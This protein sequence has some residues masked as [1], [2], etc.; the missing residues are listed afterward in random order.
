MEETWRHREEIRNLLLPGTIQHAI[1]NVAAYRKL[2]GSGASQLQRI[3]DLRNLPIVEKE[4]MLD[5]TESFRDPN[6]A[7]MLIQHTTGTS[8]NMLVLHR[9]AEEVEFINQFFTE[10]HSELSSD[11][12][13]CISLTANHHGNPTPIPYPG[14]V[15]PLD[16]NDAGWKRHVEQIVSRP[17]TFTG[18]KSEASILVG[19][20]SQLRI[21]TC[22]LLEAGYDFSRSSV[23]A[24]LSTGDLISERLQK[25]Y[26]STWRVPLHD[27]YSLTEIGGG[28]ANKCDNCGYWHL[29]PQI[30]GEAVDPITR[31]IIA[32]GFGV[33]ILTGLYP[34]IQK[35]PIIRYW[36]GDYIQL[37]E[38]KCNI[39]RFG[40]SYKGRFAR[41]LVDTTQAGTFPILA[42]AD[43]YDVLDNFPDIASSQMFKSISGIT[44][45]SALGHLKCDF[46][47]E[48]INGVRVVKLRVELRYPSYMYPERAA[49]LCQEIER[50]ML[51]RHPYLVRLVEAG[52]AAFRVETSLP[53]TL[54]GFN[55]DVVE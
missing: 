40:F 19:L 11:Q 14:D 50:R 10:V 13:V 33:L 35:Q 28:G 44:D 43:V 3:S 29:D 46:N 6:I 2:L 23:K 21:L 51:E 4:M 27:R 39:D 18:G 17:S 24:L 16:L 26:E 9:G 20:E 52:L 53:G 55:P 36:S 42:A 22:L 12:P 32:E 45:H 15:F 5:D 30:I 7:T 47:E 1:T 37:S 41:C 31:E 48:K 38:T 25:W 49:Q 8:G 34:F 54:I